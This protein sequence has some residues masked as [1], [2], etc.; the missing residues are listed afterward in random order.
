M[1]HISGV[2]RSLYNQ[3]G[4]HG[5]SQFSIAKVH[6]LPQGMLID[7]FPTKNEQTLQGIVSAIAHEKGV[8]IE[9]RVLH[10]LE[11][12][13]KVYHSAIFGRDQATEDLLKYA[14]TNQ[15]QWDSG[16]GRAY[17]SV[18]FYEGG[19]GSSAIDIVKGDH[20]IG[21]YAVSPAS[22]A[23]KKNIY[24]KRAILRRVYQFCQRNGYGPMQLTLLKGY[25]NGAG[26]NLEPTIVNSQPEPAEKQSSQ[27]LNK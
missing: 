20:V 21:I 22:T 19:E 7:F 18:E 23:G 17:D 2:A 13:C 11:D 4:P 10:T 1:R 9:A 25:R 6:R 26:W 15:S 27:A 16:K 8:P 24:R 12:Y 5:K 3:F 14:L